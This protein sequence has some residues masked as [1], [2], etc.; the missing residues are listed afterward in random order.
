MTN[1]LPKLRSDLIVSQQAAKGRVSFVIKDPENGQFFRFQEPEHFI[2]RQLD[3]STQSDEVCRRVQEKFGVELETET[4]E[5]FVK[6]LEQC[7]LLEIGTIAAGA[8]ARKQGRF[9][10][11]LLYFRF[12]VCDPDRLFDRLIGKVQFCFTPHFVVLSAAAI[13]LACCTLAFNWPQ[14][15]H[16]LPG[17]Y[18]LATI[19]LIVAIILLVTAAH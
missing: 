15:Q 12:K 13:F 3:G 14:F 18:R 5:S 19:P 2:A 4:L 7:R 1:Q 11:S 16:S 10:G 9:R 6:T 8:K 17:L